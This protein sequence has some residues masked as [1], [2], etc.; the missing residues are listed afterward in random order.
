[1]QEN[2]LKYFSKLFPDFGILGLFFKQT[3]LKNAPLEFAHI[4]GVRRPLAGDAGK[5]AELSDSEAKQAFQL[6]PFIY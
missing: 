3:F 6:V 5:L 1:M 2:F 4:H